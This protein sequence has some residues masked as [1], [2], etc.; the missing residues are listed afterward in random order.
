[1]SG[2]ET[3]APRAQLP[4]LDWQQ[5]WQPADLKTRLERDFPPLFR[6]GLG[7]REEERQRLQE[8]IEAT[9]AC[10]IDLAGDRQK[11][12]MI[13]FLF[14]A[15]Q[16]TAKNHNRKQ[17]MDLYRFALDGVPYTILRKAIG[18]I[19]RGQADGLS[20]VFLPTT[21]ELVHYCNSLT[22]QAYGSIDKAQRLLDAPE[23]Q[24][25]ER[26]SPE[27]AAEIRR[28]MKL[29]AQLSERKEAGPA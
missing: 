21:A 12:E 13:S 19:V 22:T 25:V 26:I 2:N 1:V 5:E 29:A 23:M 28:Q 9:K 7:L 17:M 27:R 8:L 20:H 3:A 6:A 4:S 18:D 16:F 11:E 14:N 24:P 15:L 10:L